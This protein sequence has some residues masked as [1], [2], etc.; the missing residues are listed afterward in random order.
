[1]RYSKDL[2]LDEDVVVK[3]LE[4]LRRHALTKLAERDRSGNNISLKIK[5]AGNVPSSVRPKTN[6]FLNYNRC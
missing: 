1:M 2:G 6:A 3:S 5:L 4:L